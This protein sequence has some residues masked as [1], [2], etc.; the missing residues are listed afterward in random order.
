MSLKNP[1]SKSTNSSDK[2][3]PFNPSKVMFHFDRL[4]DIVKGDM[5]A[6]VT[7]EID[8]SNIC[9]HNCVW[10]MFADFKKERPVSIPQEKLRSIIIELS[11]IGVRS[12]TFTGGGEPLCNPATPDAMRLCRDLNVECGLVT[13]G[14]LIHDHLETIAKTCKFCRISL[15]AGTKVTH[16]KL[17]RPKA[18]RR[19]NEILEDI[20][21]LKRLNP[22][23]TIGVAFL[24][25][26]ENYY[27]IEIVTR[28]VK[29]TK[30]DYIQ[31]RPVIQG[32][33]FS[34]ASK[35][36]ELI[37]EARAHADDDFKV[38]AIMHRFTEIFDIKRKFSKCRATPLICSIGADLNVYICCQLR[39]D[40]KFIIGNLKDKSFKE[41]WWS[42]HHQKIIDS[43]DITKCP[44]CRYIPYNEIL[45]KCVLNDQMH[46]N[47]L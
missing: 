44:V 22:N 11:K 24:V 31:I 6:P 47:F 5:P 32:I 16:E 18:G 7:V 42:D 1:E 12:I 28:K 34:T 38:Y 29:E 17:H 4:R 36:Q 26:D 20:K 2:Y 10:C 39:G 41:I 33:S 45:E 46:R 37:E 3:I 30:A 8:P 13:N 23:M 21:T 40:P 25:H 9:N 35:A 43:I 15:D 27:E 14:G 19:F